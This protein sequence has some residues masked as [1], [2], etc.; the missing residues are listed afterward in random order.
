MTDRLG[1]LAEAV[2]EKYSAQDQQKIFSCLREFT[3][4]LR[5]DADV[6]TG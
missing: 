6:P 3:E 5:E 2:L 4:E 1:R